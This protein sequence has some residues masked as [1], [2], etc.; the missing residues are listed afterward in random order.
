MIKS[1]FFRMISLGTLVFL[2][3]ILMAG[4]HNDAPSMQGTK[5]DISSFYAFQA[6]N[7]DNLVLIMNL[8]G[9]IPPGNPT[10]QAEFDE[11]ILMEFNIDL[12]NDLKEDVL[13]QAIKRRDSMYFF[14]PFQ[15]SEAGLESMINTSVM[16]KVKISTKE[17]VHI[18]EETGMKF[19]AGPREDPFFFDKNQFDLIMSGNA[20]SGFTDP[21][22]DSFAGTNVLSI[23]VE[24]PKSRLGMPVTNVNPFAPNTPTY[25]MWVETKRKIQ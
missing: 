16:H 19:F 17:E 22:N 2:A 24:L 5:A 12:N 25:S 6:S 20:T 3:V 15:T 8:Q 18:T 13:I 23:V 9:L 11:Q 14:G 7:P 4:D 1:K 21:G 10:E